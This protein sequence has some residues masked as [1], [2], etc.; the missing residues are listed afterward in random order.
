EIERLREEY[1]FFH[2]HL[3]FP[4]IFQIRD[5]DQHADPGTSWSGG[6]SCVQANPPWDKVDFEDKKY[7]SVVEPSIALKKVRTCWRT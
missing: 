4:D 2:W 1:G 5:D 3:E 6:F 7:F